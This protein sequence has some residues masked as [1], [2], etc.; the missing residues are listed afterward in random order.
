VEIATAERSSH[1]IGELALHLQ[2]KLLRF[3]QEKV[4]LPRGG[5]RPLRVEVR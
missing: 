2:P 3:I 5:T 4:F 1:E